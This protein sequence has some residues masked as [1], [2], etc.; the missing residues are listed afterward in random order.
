MVNAEN[1]SPMSRETERAKQRKPA[2]ATRQARRAP[3]A[4]SAAIGA[5]NASRLITAAISSVADGVEARALGR[6]AIAVIG[7]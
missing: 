6:K 4:Y 7:P 1:A 5:K 3:A 2:A